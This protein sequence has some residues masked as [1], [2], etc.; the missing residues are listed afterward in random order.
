MLLVAALGLHAAT[1]F[2]DARLHV[3]IDCHNITAK[4][5]PLYLGDARAAGADAVQIMSIHSSKGLQYPIVIIVGASDDIMPDS[6]EGSD[7]EGEERRIA[8]VSVSRAMDQ[9]HVF[10][11]VKTS[12]N[13]ETKP[14]R[15]F[16]KFFNKK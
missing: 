5:L 16:A 4:S 14:S 12:R 1:G 10:C 11:S 8:Y 2:A 15:Y 6:H 7:V 3:Q 13:K 9:L